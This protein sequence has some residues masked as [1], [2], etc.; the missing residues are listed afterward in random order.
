MEGGK[1]RGGEGAQIERPTMLGRGEWG[2]GAPSPADYEV[3][4]WENG[5]Y[6]FLYQLKT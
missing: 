5:F 2:E 1:K 4:V 3:W 6:G